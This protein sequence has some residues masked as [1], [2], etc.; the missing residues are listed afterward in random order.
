MDADSTSQLGDT[1]NW[2][3][4]LAAC[5]HDEVGELVDDKH[6]VRQETVTLGGQQLAGLELLVVFDD[7]AALSGFEEVVALVHLNAQGVERAHHFLH[8]GDDGVLRIGELGQIMA[9][10]AVVKRQFHLLRVDHDE[11]QLRRMLAVKQ[12]SD[13]GIQSY[14]LTLTCGTCHED[15]RH[16]GQV[17]DVGLVGDGLADGAGQGIF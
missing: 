6:D 11:F 16:L 14:R 9:L 1:C 10:N 12:R 3:F 5:G 2:G 7:V 13:D 17:E 15:V 4:H 8:I